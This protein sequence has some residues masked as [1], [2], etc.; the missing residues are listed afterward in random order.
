MSQVPQSH[1]SSVRRLAREVFPLLATNFAVIVAPK[2]EADMG[3]GL[4]VGLNLNRVNSK[5]MESMPAQV[6]QETN[7]KEQR[8]LPRTI[9]LCLQGILNF[10]APR[11]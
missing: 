1:R 5:L 3:G 7:G 8:M 11:D 9:P 6:H 4:E 2:E 10:D